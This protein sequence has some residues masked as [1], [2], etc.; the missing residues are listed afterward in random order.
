MKL[1]CYKGY[2]GGDFTLMNNL[3]FCYQHDARLHPSQLPNTTTISLFNNDNSAVVSHVNQTTGIFLSIDEQ[4][5]TASLLQELADPDDTIYSVSQGNMEVL[6]SGN[7]VMGYGS[8]PT[9][10]E[11]DQDGNV[12]LSVS[13]GEA[14]AVQSYRSYK[15]EWVGKPSSK[16]DVYACKSSN[17]TEVYMSWNGATEHRVWTV[18]GGVSNGSLSEVVSVNKTGFETKAVVTQSLGFVRVEA[19]GR[20]IENGVSNVAGVVEMC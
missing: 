6:P 2:S 8:V 5:M 12:V 4:D 17:G 14:E 20:E 7:I 3:S 1:T 13:W 18:F 10:K 9:L 16:P 15:A 19:S 11:F